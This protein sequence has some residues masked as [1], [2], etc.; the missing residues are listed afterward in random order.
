MA[1]PHA[2]PPTSPP[3]CPAKSTVPSRLINTEMTVMMPMMQHSCDLDSDGI[4]PLHRKTVWAHVQH[5]VSWCITGRYPSSPFTNF[6][7]QIGKCFP[8]FVFRPVELTEQ[9]RFLL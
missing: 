4:L 8:C 5:D 1:N 3:R 2:Y 6:L 9:H 7:I